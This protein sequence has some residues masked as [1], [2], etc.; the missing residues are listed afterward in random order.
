MRINVYDG[1]KIIGTVDIRDVIWTD[2]WGGNGYSEK[3]R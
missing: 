2:N 1:G 3:E